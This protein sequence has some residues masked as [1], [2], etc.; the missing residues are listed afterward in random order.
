MVQLFIIVILGYVLGKLGLIDDQTNIKLSGIVANVT[1]PIWVV[2][3]VLVVD[4][5]NRFGILV[6]IL[7][8]FVMYVLFIIFAKF[9]TKILRYS[10]KERPLYENMLIF[11]STSIGFPIIE[12]LLGTQAIFYGSMIHFAFNFFAYSYGIITIDY[13]KTSE[14][15]P[16]EEKSKK[17]FDYK[18]M[19]NSGFIL[20]VIALVLYLIGFRDNGVL[21]KTTKMLGELTPPLSMLLLG[22]CLTK[23]QIFDCVRHWKN[24]LFSC[25]RLFAIPLLSVAFCK[26]LHINDYYTTI[27]TLTNAMPSGS[28]VLILVTQAGIDTR[29]VFENMFLSTALSTITVPIIGSIFL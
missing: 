26:L 29:I 2:A 1:C 21:Y 3:A 24:F 6:L 27:I 15:E 13:C 12:T 20:S 14:L 19:I 4:S 25:V 10:E 16:F 22:Y 28:L 5:Q 17:G 8:G 18:M 23:Y 9:A 11:S 7:G